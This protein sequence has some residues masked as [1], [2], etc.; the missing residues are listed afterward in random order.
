MVVWWL[1]EELQMSGS[2]L[3]GKREERE[4]W[5]GGVVAW[6]CNTCT[7]N[8]Y[9]YHKIHMNNIQIEANEMQELYIHNLFAFVIRNDN[10]VLDFQ[11]LLQE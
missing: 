11:V 10:F 1:E 4:E 6:V 2:G 5:S 7:I 9:A 3:A 8:L